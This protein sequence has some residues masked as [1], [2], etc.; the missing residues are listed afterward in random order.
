MLGR[1]RW[2]SR[3]PIVTGAG[4][5]AGFRAVRGGSRHGDRRPG[6]GGGVVMETRETEG[7]GGL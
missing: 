1:E 7:G 5:I 4:G 2:S 3:D 6:G